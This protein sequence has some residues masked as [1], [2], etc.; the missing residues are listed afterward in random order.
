MLGE[1]PTINIG[2]LVNL[3]GIDGDTSAKIAQMVNIMRKKRAGNL[4]RQAYLTGKYSLMANGKL[5]FTMPPQIGKLEPVVG[6][7]AKAVTSLEQR[8]N[9]TGFV[10]PEDSKAAKLWDEIAEKNRFTELKT[11]QQTQ[12]LAHG[13][14]FITVTVDEENQPLLTLHSPANATCIWDPVTRQVTA[15]LTVIPAT[16]T[17]PGRA[18][19]WLPGLLIETTYSKNGWS[20]PVFYEHGGGVSM[21][22]MVYQETTDAYGTP[23]VSREVMSITDQATRTLLR[24]EV[25]AE[26][27][28]LPQR[29][30][31]GISERAFK[32]KSAFKQTVARI[33]G[34]DRD[35]DTGEAPQVGQFPAASP[36]AHIAQLR[37]LA[38][39]FCGATGVPL[40]L[41]GVVQDN[42]SSADA[43]RAAESE[44]VMIAERAQDSLGASWVRVVETALKVAGHE[45]KG[46]VIP[47]WR[48]PATPTKAATAQSVVA[49]VQAGILPPQSRVVWEQ[50][51]YDEGTIAR[52]QA[53]AAKASGDA[54]LNAV[55]SAQDAQAASQAAT[56]IDTGVAN[57]PIPTG[58][59]QAG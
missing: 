37:A 19:I 3:E 48:D 44:L 10:F 57:P 9:L 20:T 14:A 56:F 4:K 52:L 42:P 32:V 11:M 7:P 43:I 49:L 8:L 45:V 34:I 31:I 39:Q 51:G 35:E 23:R 28:S 25:G 54:F 29:Y 21:E 12:S 13:V 16:E 2:D 6:W 5:G 30:I 55:I 24:M 33:W 47:I 15:G 58:E 22:R 27:Y 1:A 40:N 18:N 26:L 38:A 53:D 46:P 17:E 41:M 59:D 36:E 50:L